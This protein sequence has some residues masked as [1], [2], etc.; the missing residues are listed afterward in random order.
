MSTSS[1]ATMIGK[2]VAQRD[3]LEHRLD[4][5]AEPAGADPQRAVPP[6]PA[7]EFLDPRQRLELAP[8]DQVHHDLALARHHAQRGFRV[9]LAIVL[10]ENV[11]ERAAIVEADQFLVVLGL[12]ELDLLGLE[13]F[14]EG[15]E[16]QRLAVD[17]YTVEIKHHGARPAGR[18]G[19]HAGDGIASEG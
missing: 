5:L 14:L 12:A 2:A 15:E 4:L 17:Q 11:P 1:A 16:V 13:G 8:A 6:Q 19:R 9:E 3:P 18:A 10:R 7:D